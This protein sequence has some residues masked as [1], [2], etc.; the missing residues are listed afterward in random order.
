M[1]DEEDV[2][3]FDALEWL[4]K[5]VVLENLAVGRACSRTG[6]QRLNTAV[7]AGALCLNCQGTSPKK[8]VSVTR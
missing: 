7:G 5:Y 1:S 4:A 6:W 8:P 3:G 2:V